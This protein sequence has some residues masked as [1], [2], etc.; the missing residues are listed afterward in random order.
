MQWR[1][2]KIIAAPPLDYLRITM[3][4]PGVDPPLNGSGAPD[5]IP[6]VSV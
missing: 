4:R 6:S 5:E 1:A 2:Q 3:S